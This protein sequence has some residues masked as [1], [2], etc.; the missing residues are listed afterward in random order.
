[1]SVQDFGVQPCKTNG[2]IIDELSTIKI[3]AIFSNIR[4]INEYFLK[5]KKACYMF[6]SSGFFPPVWQ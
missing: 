4:L 5:E 6:L 3:T 1:M 2:W